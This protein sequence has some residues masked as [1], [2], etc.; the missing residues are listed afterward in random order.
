MGGLDGAIAK[1]QASAF[2]PLKQFILAAKQAGILAETGTTEQKRDV[3]RNI[4][5]NP[6]VFNR[7]V[8]FHPRGAWQLV[9][10]QGSFAHP[11]TAA[12]HDAAAICGE[13]RDVDLKR[14]QWDSLRTFFKDNP[15]W[16]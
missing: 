1:N 13:T 5:S 2:E 6:N 12:S 9:I 8:R 15:G 11:V 14:S 10:R 7:T 16:K 4:A 3:F